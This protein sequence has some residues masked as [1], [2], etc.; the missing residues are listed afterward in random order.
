MDTPILNP[1]LSGTIKI[2]GFTFARSGGHALTLTTTGT[3]NVTLPT[4]GTLATLAGTETLSNKTVTGPSV[5]V[6]GALTANSGNALA[7]VIL[8]G[9]PSAPTAYG[10]V[11]FGVTPSNTNYTFLGDAT[12]GNSYVNAVA[13]LYLRISNSDVIS[14]T[15]TRA[16]MAQPLRLKTYTVGTL[17]TGAEGDT[18]YVTDATAPTYLGALTGGGAVKCKVFYNG[19]AW[20][21]C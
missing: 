19:S 17:P 21:S 13:N 15:A 4:T 9:Y 8:Q 2:D 7:K 5:T 6:T 10:G 18:A 12:G 14:I 11:W 3:T 1:L 20:V 16:T